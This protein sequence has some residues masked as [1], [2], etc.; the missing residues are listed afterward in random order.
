MY[1]DAGV[2]AMKKYLVRPLEIKAV[3]DDGTFEG[4]GS[5]FH[6]EDDYKD[7][8]IPGAF[9]KSIAHHK[10][11]GIM[12]ALLWQHNS[13]KP[14]GVWEEMAEDEHGL[15]CKGRLLIDD[16][17]LAKEA[18][19]LLKAGAISG[20]SIG[21]RTIVD[22][23]DRDSGVST[24]KELELWETSLVTFPANDAARVTSVKS[25]RDFETFLRDA[26]GFSIAEAKTIA[27]YGF[28]GQR[29]AD[30]ELAEMINKNINIL[31]SEGG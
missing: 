16:V 28:K 6:I 1:N 3:N 2:L 23:Y 15:K 26:G 5:V 17:Q 7:V 11:K 31:T 29:D 25:V 10:S 30:V 18:H 13:A 21:Y 19:A 24:L 27:L 22:E 14:L 20:L 8:V 9:V 4:Y 12:P